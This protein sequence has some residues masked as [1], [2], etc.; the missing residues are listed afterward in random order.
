MASLAA[1]DLED[2]WWLC[3]VEDRRR[4]GAS[5]EGMLEGFS[6]GSGLLLVDYIG[7]LCRQGKARLSRE[8]A[9]ILERLETGAEVW[10]QRMR[11]LFGKARL[12][13]SYFS[14]DCQRLRDVACR[15]RSHHLDNAVAA[16]A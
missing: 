14:T 2:D 5:R 7:R 16:F 4:Q 1:G 9:S 8:M 10:W 12:L 3:S 13:G 11:E 6:L 15:R